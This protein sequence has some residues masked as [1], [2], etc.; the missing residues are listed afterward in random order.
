M[1]NPIKLYNHCLDY[2]ML[3]QQKKD[4]L[5]EKINNVLYHFENYLTLAINDCIHDMNNYHKKRQYILQRNYFI[6]YFKHNIHNTTSYIHS[7]SSDEHFSNYMN[8][9]IIK[10]YFRSSVEKIKNILKGIVFVDNVLNIFNVSDTKYIVID[11]IIINGEFIYDNVIE[12]DHDR[13]PPKK[14]YRK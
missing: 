1:E 5:A 3:F 10:Q 6:T 13:L 4:F 7:N 12:D 2:I 14:R 11:N 9:H 8:Y